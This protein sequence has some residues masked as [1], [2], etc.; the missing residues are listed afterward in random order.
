MACSL[1]FIVFRCDMQQ[2]FRA[3]F[4]VRCTQALRI[5][6]I[7]KVILIDINIR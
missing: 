7:K 4:T 1:G 3:V 2:I 6:F 5:A